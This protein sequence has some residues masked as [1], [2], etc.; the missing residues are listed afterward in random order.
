MKV[1]V[2]QM[3]QVAETDR[4]FRCDLVRALREASARDHTGFF[5]TQ[6]FNNEPAL[7][8]H[9]SESGSDFV[10]RAQEIVNNAERLHIPLDEL[11]ATV[12]LTHFREVANSNDPQSIGP[13]RRFQEF[14][15][16]LEKQET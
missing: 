5:N 4:Q 12:A 7:R 9:A 3:I 10:R 8:N 13:R 16:D 1:R 11:A 15:D 14:I 6:Q 2:N